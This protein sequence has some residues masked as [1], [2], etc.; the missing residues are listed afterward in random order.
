MVFIYISIAYLEPPPVRGI[1]TPTLNLEN[2]I[3]K[4]PRYKCRLLVQLFLDSPTRHILLTPTATW[5][6][7]IRIC[8]RAH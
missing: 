7:L 8:I 6:A 3:N 2:L 4:R 5:R 1:V